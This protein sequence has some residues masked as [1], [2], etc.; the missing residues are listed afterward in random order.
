MGSAMVA[1]QSQTAAFG[2]ARRLA[3]T[4]GGIGLVVV[5]LLGLGIYVASRRIARPILAIASTARAVA[6]GDLERD[7][8]VMTEDEVG[9]L[10]RVFNDML[11][12]VRERER[13]LKEQVQQ[14][15]IEI[16]EVRAAQKVAEITETDYF[17]DLQ[18]R[19]SGLRRRGGG[20]TDPG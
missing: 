11:S 19:A 2:P 6:A 20:P 17:R 7:A 16:D 1:Y 5:A 8:P 4:S 3:F 12:K 14:L 13:R 15:R 9:A 18:K 10:A